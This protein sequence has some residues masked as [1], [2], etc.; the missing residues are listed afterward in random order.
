MN[1]ET[2]KKLALIITANCTRDSILQ[3]SLETGTFSQTQF[4]DF[5]KQMSDRIYTFLTF[6]LNKP[7]EEY[8]VMMSELAK[9]FPEDWS[10]PDLEQSFMQLVDQ[11]GP[12]S[13]SQTH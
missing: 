12:S 9:H 3:D 5:N 2:V 6:L 8:S 11:S 13:I 10:M 7:A 4:N 1:E